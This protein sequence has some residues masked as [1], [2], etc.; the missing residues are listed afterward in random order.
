MEERWNKTATSKPLFKAY[1][2][3]ENPNQTYDN[4]LDQYPGPGSANPTMQS[5][6]LKNF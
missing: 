3:Y 5:N 2:T 6:R 4:R 1:N